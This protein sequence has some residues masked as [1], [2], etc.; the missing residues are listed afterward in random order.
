MNDSPSLPNGQGRPEDFDG[1]RAELAKFVDDFVPVAD[2]L[3]PHLEAHRSQWELY[4]YGLADGYEKLIASDIVDQLGTA[5]IN[6]AGARD[7]LSHA[8]LKADGHSSDS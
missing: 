6:L 5:L 1:L 7:R 2:D 8:F 4:K 3:W